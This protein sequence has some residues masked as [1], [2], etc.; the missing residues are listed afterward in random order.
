MTLRCD[1]TTSN[2]YE[3]LAPSKWISIN[4]SS[5]FPPP[6]IPRCSIVGFSQFSVYRCANYTLLT[7]T[8]CG[9]HIKHI[10]HIRILCFSRSHIMLCKFAVSCTFYFTFSLADVCTRYLS[11]FTIE[12]VLRLLYTV[13]SY[14]VQFRC[15]CIRIPIDCTVRFH[16]IA[17]LMRQFCCSSTVDGKEEE[18]RWNGSKGLRRASHSC[19]SIF[20]H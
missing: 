16:C 9:S 17:L 13:H 6:Y 19:H 8:M 7:R 14:C 3:G 5:S 4:V 2:K 1:G 18:G 10:V 20:F 12:S 15:Y 11:A